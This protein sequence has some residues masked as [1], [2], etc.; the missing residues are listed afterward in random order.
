MITS[1]DWTFL[2]PNLAP[3][4]LLNL[5]SPS[6]DPQNG[7]DE[8][9][10]SSIELKVGVH[11]EYVVSH[12]HLDSP[13]DEFLLVD[14]IIGVD[15]GLPIKY[16]LPMHRSTNFGVN[17]SSLV[18]YAKVTYTAEGFRVDNTRI[19]VTINRSIPLTLLHTIMVLLFVQYGTLSRIP[20]CLGIRLPPISL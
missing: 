18:D 15:F 13:S 7:I 5:I 3:I 17:K 16:D 12:I 4:F 20:C 14:S 19:Q 1:L 11:Y 10:N 6:I 8:S 2:Q 9:S